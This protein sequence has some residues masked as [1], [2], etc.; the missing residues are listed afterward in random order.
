[1]P[2]VSVTPPPDGKEIPTSQASEGK[3][4]PVSHVES[5][6]S[7]S[8]LA[9]DAD[10]IV[11]LIQRVDQFQKRVSRSIEGVR[12]ASGS[13]ETAASESLETIL[14]RFELTLQKVLELARNLEEIVRKEKEFFSQMNLWCREMESLEAHLGRMPLQ[15]AWQT[16]LIARLKKWRQNVAKSL[17]GIEEEEKISSSTRQRILRMKK[18]HHALAA[19]LFERYREIQRGYRAE[20]KVASLSNTLELVRALLSSLQGEYLEKEELGIKE[21]L[22]NAHRACSQMAIDLREEPPPPP[23]VGVI[24]AGSVMEP[25][26]AN[27]MVAYLIVQSRVPPIFVDPEELYVKR[28]RKALADSLAAYR[29]QLEEHRLRCCQD[30]VSLEKRFEEFVRVHLAPGVLQPMGEAAEKDSSRAPR[31]RQTLQRIREAAGISHPS[32][33]DG[34]GPRY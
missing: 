16:G 8:P 21:G 29:N 9:T 1:M 7:T 27:K 34:P 6:D 3:N 18:Q 31:I 20:P 19:L 13:G 26:I 22:I 14:H 30:P 10:P 33:S 17:A 24:E 4:P 32:I 28:V 23:P 5:H 15:N 2:D 11:S 12:S 25:S